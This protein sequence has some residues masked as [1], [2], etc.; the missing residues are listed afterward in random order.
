M[1][2][3]KNIEIKHTKNTS[4]KNLKFNNSKI[5]KTENYL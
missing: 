3:F 5:F 4:T 1:G 2:Y